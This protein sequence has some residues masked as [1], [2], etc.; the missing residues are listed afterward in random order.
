MLPPEAISVY[1]AR[2]MPKRRWLEAWMVAAV[3]VVAVLAW[4]DARMESSQAANDLAA[5][6]ARA[7]S[8]IVSL[9]R[10][11]A[12]WSDD[13]KGALIGAGAQLE[14]VHPAKLLFRGPDGFV[15]WLGRPIPEL[16]AA[17]DAPKAVVPGERAER[18]GLP[19]RMG[20]GVV[21]TFETPAGPVTV[22]LIASAA[23]MRD[24]EARAGLRL[25]LSVL[26]AAGIVL[27]FG[28]MALKRQREE[29]ELSHRL[30]IAELSRLSEEQLSKADKLATAGALATGIA[31]EV[32]TPL[33]IIVA[34]AE[35]LKAA[36]GDQPRAARAADTVLAQAERI[37]AIVRGLLGL[38]RG[39]PAGFQSVDP[40]EFA[41]EAKGL[42]DHR[43]ERAGITLELKV[44]PQLPALRCDRL[45]LSQ[46][47]VNL[48]LNACEACTRGGQVTLSAMRDGAHLALV[49]ED[50]GAGITPEVALRAAEPLFTTKIG[51]GTGLGLKIA[52]EIVKHHQGKLELAPR[53]DRRGTRVVLRLPV[54]TEAVDAAA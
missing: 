17:I 49:V 40:L 48:L 36:V 51:T 31:H 37:G 7:L 13:P 29:L 41:L 44:P 5:D 34:R 24:R 46:A 4:L 14:R 6:Q 26:A 47:L 38:I 9:A 53:E 21:R 32:S 10:D 27:G 22:A 2:A 39:E 12:R 1:R 11:S 35:Q 45:L 8:T 19:A 43:F 3:A 28:L 23:S 52:S 18:L 42:V 33:S 15:D 30:A 25:F 54:A 50:D 20:I 16:E